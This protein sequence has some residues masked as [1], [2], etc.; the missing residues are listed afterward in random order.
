MEDRCNSASTVCIQIIFLL[1]NF[2]RNILASKQSFYAVLLSSYE[3]GFANDIIKI[4]T[5]HIMASIET[6]RINQW[7]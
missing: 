1:Y 7:F 5:A 4:R 6:H 2:I 3:E